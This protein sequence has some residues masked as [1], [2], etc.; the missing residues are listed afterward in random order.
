M[1]AGLVDTRR[2][3]F[4]RVLVGVALA[5]ILAYAAFLRLDALFGKYGPFTHPAWVVQ[6]ERG[7]AA[8]RGTLVPDD[9]TWTPPDRR[10][11]GDPQNYIRFARE[12]RRFYQAHVREPVF[13]AATRGFMWLTGGLDESVSF[14]SAA[15]STVCVLAI[16][17]LG[18]AMHSTGAGLAAAALLAVE[19]EAI[20]WA[21]DGWRD[22]AYTAMVALSAWGIVRMSRR[23]EM[24][25]GAV[26]GLMAAG[27]CL[28]RVSALTFI[29]PV[30]AAFVI[31]GDRYAWRPRAR[32]A[33]MAL[34]VFAVVTG[35]YFFAITRET[36]DP[37]FAV[38]YHTIYYLDHEGDDPNLGLS[39]AEYVARKFQATPMLTSEIALRGLTDVPFENKWNGFGSWLPGLGA[40]LRL[41][42]I[43]G[44]LGWL[45][46]PAGRLLLLM[47]VGVLAPYMVTWTVGDGAA[48]RFTM[49]AYPFYLA[50]AVWFAGEAIRWA[51]KARDAEW[52]AARPARAL[53]RLAIAIGLVALFFAV[54][55]QMPYLVA[56]ESLLRGQDTS[57]AAGDRD[58]VFFADGWT[59]LAREG[60]VTA[61][62]AAGERAAL[63]L[64]LPERR[65]YHVMLRMD[66]LPFAGAPPQRVRVSL[67][68]HPLAEWTLVYSPER[69]GA[70][71]LD[72]PA[73]LVDPG[74]AR[75]E[76]AADFVRP[77]A[78][79]G[80]AYPEIP[81]DQPAAFRFWY[82]RITPR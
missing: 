25:P 54:T 1:A 4:R 44:L 11:Y 46:V 37:F 75:L 51:L 34:A 72:I 53:P 15:F 7:V 29:A 71:E 26:F 6:L 5:G 22:D 55:R 57:V 33:G 13:L 20:H 45:F 64:P 23:P 17:L 31:V 14:A 43:A 2:R 28:T 65:G 74:R 61:R 50:A 58:L 67:D 12:M 16:F 66:P 9:W 63:V 77:M 10:Y 48:W 40:T 39:A 81:R 27:A 79:A 52:R 59:G 56:R 21:P 69:V 49:P 42:A 38:N 30:L 35:P 62:M 60:N 32:S 24:G 78:A 8:A 70:Y 3:F 47:L 36:G 19:R 73:D 82:A 18:R 68:G 80:D 76:L 41:L